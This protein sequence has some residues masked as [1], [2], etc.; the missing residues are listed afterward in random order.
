MWKVAAPPPPHHYRPLFPDI[1]DDRPYVWPVRS[2]TVMAAEQR[3]ADM[4]VRRQ[5]RALERNRLEFERLRRKH[6]RAAKKAWQ[7]RRENSARPT[8]AGSDTAKDG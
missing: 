3:K 6:S 4:E 1:P 2:Q 5:Q 8:R 7:T